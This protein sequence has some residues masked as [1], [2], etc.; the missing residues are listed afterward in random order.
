MQSVS[1]PPQSSVSVPMKC[2]VRGC[3]ASAIDLLVRSQ[4]VATFRCAVCHFSWSAPIDGLPLFVRQ[5][6]DALFSAY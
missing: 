3:D 4:T 5:H 6:L 1:L 2:P